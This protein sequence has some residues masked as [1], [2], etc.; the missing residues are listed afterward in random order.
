MVLH[1]TQNKGGKVCCRKILN[2]NIIRNAIANTN[3]IEFTYKGHRRIAEP[4]VYGIKNEKRQ[5]LVYQ[6]GGGTSSGRIPDWRR[7]A[8]DEI[9]GFKATD[10]KFASARDIPSGDYSDWDVIIA[11]VE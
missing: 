3:I 9:S 10:Q 7:V 6:V 2:A 8:I 4:H 1:R 5:L 11:R